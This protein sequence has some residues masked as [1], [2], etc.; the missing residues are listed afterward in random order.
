MTQV[1]RRYHE[2]STAGIA[3]RVAQDM[4]RTRDERMTAAVDALWE[5][6]S[7]TGL[8]WVGFYIFVPRCILREDGGIMGGEEG[9]AADNGLV[10]GP[11]RDKPACSPIG[12]NGAC[13][14][15][16]LSKRSL[17]V[18][19]VAHL[20]ARY[21]ACD[22]RDRSEVVVPCFN[23][24]GTVW[25]VLDADSFEVNAFG[26]RD[27]EELARLLHAWGLSAKADVEIDVV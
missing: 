24:D 16:Y 13:G 23:A 18:T 15:S 6:L 20:G 17:V 27:A 25:G 1:A 2:L 12:L 10:L 5:R 21:I 4:P 9:G 14:R 3:A 22:P 11:C 19:D 26:E 8:S 7:L